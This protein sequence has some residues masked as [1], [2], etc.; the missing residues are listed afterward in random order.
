MSEEDIGVSQ[1]NV[2][3][4]QFNVDANLNNEDNSNQQLNISNTNTGAGSGDPGLYA[5]DPRD[6]IAVQN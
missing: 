6:N 4:Q 5:L 2:T 1:Q 3:T